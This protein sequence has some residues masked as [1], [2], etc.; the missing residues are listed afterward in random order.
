ML[1]DPGGVETRSLMDEPGWLVRQAFLLGVEVFWLRDK[2]LRLVRQSLSINLGPALL[3]H[4]PFGL[5]N[6]T[7]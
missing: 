2:C 3:R 6:H 4:E 7:R 5:S 1:L